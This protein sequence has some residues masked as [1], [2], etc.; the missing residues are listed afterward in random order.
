MRQPPGFEHPQTPHFICKLDKALYGLKQ[1]PR[2]WFARL[3]TKLH[4]LGFVSSKAD[5]SLFL[6]QKHAIIIY[7]LIYVDDIIVTSSSDKAIGTLLHDL[8]DDFALKDL[9]PLHFFLGIEVKQT[10]DGLRLTQEKYAADLLTK[11]GMIQCASSPT[12]LSSN[13]PLSLL[14]GNLLGPDD[15]TRYR[16][17]VGALQYLTLTRPDISFSVNKV[18]QFLHAPTTIHWTI[19]KRILRYIK[20]TL[21]LGL[22]FKRSSSSLLSAFSDAD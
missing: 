11:V 1:A 21:K 2:A 6:Y 16:S 13:E 10:Y 9:G 15:S 4:D 14:Q 3:S 20:G 12:P 22:S 7:V 17:I 8:R 5:T 19:V 18:C